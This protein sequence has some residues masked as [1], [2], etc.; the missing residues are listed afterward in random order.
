L[1]TTPLKPHEFHL[2]ES[3]YRL[4]LGGRGTTLAVGGYYGRTDAEPDERTSGFRG[5]S[6][7]VEVE[8][9]HP[10]ERSR[11]RSLWLTGRLELRDSELE[12]GASM[13]R[14]DRI[15]SGTLS[16]HGFNQLAGGK[17]RMRA[18]LVQG[19]DLLGATRLGDP[20]ASRRDAD[21]VFTKF[22]GWAEYIRPLGKSFSAR[23]AVR[24]QVADGPLLSSEEM[25]LGGAQ[26]LRAFDYRERSGDRGVAGS[27]ELRFDLRDAVQFVDNI[28]FYGYADA[29]RVS[30]LAGGFGG[31]SL[32]SAGGG[33]RLDIWKRWDLGLEVGV[34]LTAGAEDASPD[35]RFSVTL[36]TRF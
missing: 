34:P 23:A 18:A 29:G 21:G 32:A 10:L 24:T 35:P 15:A 19:V 8:A 17:L 1:A 13:V 12:R 30:N 11:R 26:F 4:P 28:Q 16:L 5:D 9:M 25:G 22:E 6:W 7:Q 33:V 20:L 3:R 2:L 27:L 36:R 31:G 14:D